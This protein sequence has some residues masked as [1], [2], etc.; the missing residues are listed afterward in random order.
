MIIKA[1]FSWFGLGWHLC[2]SA[3]I[4]YALAGLMYEWSHYIVHT[5]VKPPSVQSSTPTSYSL[6]PLKAMTSTV[7][8]LFSHM[9]NN[10]IRHHLVDDRFWYAFSVPV[11]DNSFH[12]NPDVRNV[13]LEQNQEKK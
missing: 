7:S 6:S 2:L 10:H 11:M 5:R 3:T 1:V 9:R 12:T 13:R 4:G 8:T